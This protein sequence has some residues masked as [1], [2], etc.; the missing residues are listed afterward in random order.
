MYSEK[1]VIL[2]A[3]MCSAF[4]TTFKGIRMIYEPN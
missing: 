1:A 3:F 4:R 2:D